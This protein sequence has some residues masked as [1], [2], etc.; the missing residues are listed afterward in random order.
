[1]QIVID[2]SYLQSTS[3]EKFRVRFADDTILFTESLLYELLTTKLETVRHA[4]FTKLSQTNG[5]IKIMPSTGPLFQH[6]MAHQRPAY[7]LIDH[8]LST[9][10]EDLVTGVSSCPLDERPALGQ[11]KQEVQREG[12]TFDMVAKSLAEWC[13]DLTSAKGLVLRQACGELKQQACSDAD[14]VRRIYTSLG[15]EDFPCAALIDPVWTMFRW[16]QMHILFG[17][18]HISRY[19]FENLTG[20][21][22][23]LEHDVH[24][25]QYALFGTLCGG[26]ATTD[27][28]IAQNFTLACPR[29]SLFS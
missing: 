15:L 17:L 19:G 13:P 9:T 21:P 18:D 10:F 14:V 8:A 26:L 28:D 2:K 3:T 29:G 24:D 4:C 1:M 11:W 6:E 20:I 27:R 25:L 12:E 7:P 23:R 22:K 16:V 5:S